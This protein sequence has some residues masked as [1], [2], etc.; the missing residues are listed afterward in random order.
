MNTAIITQIV[1]TFN[2]IV[3]YYVLII[4]SINFLQLFLSAFSLYDYIKKMHYSDY[5]KYTAS[6]N[7]IPISVLVPAYNEESTIVDNIKSLLALNYPSHEVIVINDGSTDS[8]FKKIVEAYNLKEIN[9]PVR[10][11]IKTKKVIK[12]TIYGMFNI[13]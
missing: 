12:Y 3:L 7:M 13:E 1:I 5:E 9:Q 11:L 6:T 8:T 4:N 10:Y 2:Q